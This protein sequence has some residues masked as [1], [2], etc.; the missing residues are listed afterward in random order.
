LPPAALLFDLLP[1]FELWLLSLIDDT[2]AVFL[3]PLLFV[4]TA[5]F[6]ETLLALVLVGMLTFVSTTPLRFGEPILLLFVLVVFVVL[7]LPPQPAAKLA[8]ARTK[9]KASLDRIRFFLP[10]LLLQNR[11][12]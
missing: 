6:D 5:V 9:D 10:C 12:A 7:S 4:T 11:K 3:L 1:L 2:P 8:A